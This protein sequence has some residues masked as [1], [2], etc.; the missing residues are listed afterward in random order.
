MPTVIY[1]NTRKFLAE[2]SEAYPYLV[3]TPIT[4]PRPDE[5]ENEMFLQGSW[6]AGAVDGMMHWRFAVA[7]DA[8]LFIQKYGSF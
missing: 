4:E 7:E 1:A 3:L 5:V 8:D 2:K 6:I